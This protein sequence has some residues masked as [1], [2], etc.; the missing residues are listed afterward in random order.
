MGSQS[1]L[2]G[3][4]IAFQALT[5]LKSIW[6]DLRVVS[7]RA[8]PSPAGL[9][10]WFDVETRP[11]QSRISEIYRSCD[12]WLFSSRAEGFGLPILEAM[13]SGTPVAATSA[14]AAP[15]LVTRDVGRR[16][17]SIDA[18]AL[19]EAAE[20]ILRLDAEEWRALSL[21]A[22]RRAE[23]NSV[24]RSAARFLAATEAALGGSQAPS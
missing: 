9:P 6:S 8:D 5:R 4:D 13:A 21:G 19:A 18:A 3:P 7:F 16:A 12:V 1:S 10:D 15:D 2:K 17:D 11:S 20:E 23:E 22:R 24:E 14:G